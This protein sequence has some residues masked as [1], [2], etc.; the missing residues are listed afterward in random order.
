MKCSEMIYS[1]NYADYMINFL[2][3]YEGGM[4]YYQ[5]GC[6]NEI[7]DKLAIFH[8][9]RGE[10]SLNNLETVPYSFIPKLYGVADIDDIVGNSERYSLVYNSNLYNVDGKDI[11]IGIIDTG[12]NYN[13]S[14]FW[15][16]QDGFKKSRILSIWDQSRPLNNLDANNPNA[17]TSNVSNFIAN[18]PFGTEYS[19]DQITAAINSINPFELVPED[20]ESGH[21]TFLAGVAAGGEQPE[22]GFR[23]VAPGAELAIVKLKEAK[24]Y[25]RDYFCIKDGVNAYQETDIIYGIQYLLALAKRYNKPISILIGVGSSLGGHFGTTFL[26]QYIDTIL[27]NV[28]VMVSVPAGNE[29]NERL[30]YRGVF[31]VTEKVQEV[32]FNIGENTKGI[33]MELWGQN[34]IIYG[35]G[36]L[37]PRGERIDLIPPRFGQ[38]EEF[39]LPLSGAS[40][41]VAYQLVEIYSGNELIFIRIVSPVAGIW[42]LLVYGEEARERKYDI[43]MPNRQFLDEETFFLLG[44]PEN[45]VVNPGNARLGV[46]FTS[47]NAL[48]GSSYLQGG[49]GFNSSNQVVPDLAAP[50]VNVVGPGG[51]DFITKTGTSVAAAYGAGIFALFLQWLQNHPELDRFYAA[52][53]KS[54]FLQNARRRDDVLYPNST[55]GYGYIDLSKVFKVFEVVK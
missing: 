30:H 20:D 9:P 41:Y 13:N 10:D 52:Q 26:E 37:S 36:I 18:I 5:E 14:L 34:P 24:Q 7:I 8:T 33:V 12:I 45:T 29:G 17:Y 23:G 2:N 49:R 54:M 46:T 53:I 35:V 3:S 51:V 44:K 31:D 25:L 19:G 16:E 22:K 32:E 4:D 21:G 55:V 28:D 50:G 42:K 40:I 47:Y 27:E 11:I 39:V 38:E 6:V 15:T 48:D 1:N 43:W